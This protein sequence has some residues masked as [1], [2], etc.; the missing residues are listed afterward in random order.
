MMHF[1][2]ES[3][4]SSPERRLLVAMLRRALFDFVGD[5]LADRRAAREWI[6]EGGRVS[7]HFS[8][9][10]ICLHLDIDSGLVKERLSSMKPGSVKAS[11]HWF[12]EQEHLQAA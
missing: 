12:N 9:E 4:N 6:F 3:S 10:W 2:A 11:A 8:F 1:S 7:E 5:N